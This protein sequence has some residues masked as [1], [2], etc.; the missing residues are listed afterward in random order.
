MKY[1]L[2]DN[3]Y[4]LHNFSWQT[5]T[6]IIMEIL[7]LAITINVDLNN[8]SKN[9]NSYCRVCCILFSQP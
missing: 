2:Q 4:H 6:G 7:A 1:K 9:P 3:G 5:V 8:A